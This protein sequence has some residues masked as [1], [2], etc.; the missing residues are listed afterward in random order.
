MY[1]Y[2]KCLRNFLDHPVYNLTLFVVSKRHNMSLK[3]RVLPS[4]YES[5]EEGEERDEDARTK[6]L[7]KVGFL[8]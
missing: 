6:K 4:V 7:K 5:P 8:K 2:E 3:K 1:R